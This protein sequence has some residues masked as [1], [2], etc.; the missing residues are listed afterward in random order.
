MLAHTEDLGRAARHSAPGALARKPEGDREPRMKGEVARICRAAR[1][2][3]EGDAG[4]FEKGSGPENGVVWVSWRGSALEGSEV[5]SGLLATSSGAV[6]P[7]RS[8]SAAWPEIHPPVGTLT[9][10]VTP[11][12]R[13]T[14][15]I[16]G[17]RVDGDR[18]FHAAIDVLDL[19]LVPR[20]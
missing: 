3:A 11:F 4:L 10:V 1:S 5:A 7:A 16:S 9:V 8:M 20:C 13:V 19:P 17:M 12:A 18:R 6:Q 2:K 14:G 15:I